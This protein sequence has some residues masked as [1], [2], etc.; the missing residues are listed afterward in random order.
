MGKRCRFSDRIRQAVD[1]S[2]MRRCAV[3]EKIGLH[4]SQMSRFMAGKGGLSMAALDRLAAL[5]KI[6]VTFPEQTDGKRVQGRKRG[7]R[8]VRGR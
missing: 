1:A 7:G 5:L 4:E 2:G 6:E 8:S 3:S